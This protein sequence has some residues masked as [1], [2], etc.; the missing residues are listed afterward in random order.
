MQRMDLHL[1]NKCKYKN[2]KLLDEDGQTLYISM[3]FCECDLQECNDD[4]G[5]N[6]EVTYNVIY[7]QQIHFSKYCGWRKENCTVDGIYRWYEL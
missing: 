7:G 6:E 2:Y 4:L 5:E 1:D 3:K